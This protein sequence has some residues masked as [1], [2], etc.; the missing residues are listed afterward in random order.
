MTKAELVERVAKVPFFKP[1]KD[2]HLL[3]DKNDL[4]IS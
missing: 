3:V 2:L 1:G 4:E